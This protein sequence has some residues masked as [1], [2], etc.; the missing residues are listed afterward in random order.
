MP[1]LRLPVVFQFTPSL[2]II[3]DYMIQDTDGTALGNAQGFVVIKPGDYR[4]KEVGFMSMTILS[5][6]IGRQFPGQ[7]CLP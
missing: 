2:C 6:R 4:K 5:W 1:E 7:D 3:Y